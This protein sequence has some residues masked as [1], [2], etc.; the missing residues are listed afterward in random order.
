MGHMTPWQV[1]MG[2]NAAQ[3]KER[4]SRLLMV[5]LNEFDPDYVAKMA[6]R[7]DLPHL[8]RVLS[9]RHSTTT[10]DDHIEHHGLDPWVQWVS[11]HCGKETKIH[12]IRRLG[13]T[14]AQVFPQ[15]WNAVADR[16]NCTWGVWGVMNAPLGDP[17][18][19]C[20]FMP[21]PWSFEEQ[22]YPVYLND[23]LALP[24]YAAR[25]YLEIDYRKAI[26]EALRLVRFFA[27]PIHWDL[28]ARFAT[29][30]LTGVANAGANIHSFTT[31]LDFLSVLCF[32][33]LRRQHAP[34]LSIIFLNNLAHLQHQFWSEGD[35][36]HPQMKLGLELCNAM[37]G[38]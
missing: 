9:F 33:K 20:F 17:R 30:S 12:G 36:L 7:L 23:L 37:F 32:R 29:K 3:K 13:V 5:E 16:S 18:L 6:I 11:I 31:L 38:G 19:A 24:R 21:D 35:N 22:A 34:D 25:N 10:T 4:S 27:A 26:T 1:V 2:S 15:I 14:K 8:R 28:L